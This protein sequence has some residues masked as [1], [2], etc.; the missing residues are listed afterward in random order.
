ME[1]NLIEAIK[2]NIS[3]NLATS[4]IPIMGVVIYG[5]W[6]RGMQTEH[7]DVDILVVSNAVNPHKHKRGKEIASLKDWLSTGLPLDVMLLTMDECISNF[8]NHNPLF[9]DIASEGIILIDSE[10]F[11]KNLIADTKNYIIQRGIIKLDD[12]WRFPSL[13]REPTYLSDVSNKD[14]AIAMITDGERDFRI[15]INIMEDGYFDKSVYHF[16][17]SVEKAVKAVLI[18]F[19]EF[20][21]SH[22]VGAVLI[23]K[24][25]EIELADNWEERLSYIAGISGEIEPEVTWSR[26]PGIEAGS[27]WLPYEEYKKEDAVGL[28]E[29]S[30]KVVMI[31]KDFI[32]WWFK[33]EEDRMSSKEIKD[34]E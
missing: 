12:G 27:L 28:K 17:Q 15:G 18:C 21:K 22:F 34:D 33:L 11:L 7:S 10:D 16:Q 9:L 2:K 29:K 24:L 5:S 14:F 20:K 1:K 13:Y 8:M 25:K 26:Y 4:P 32:K 23:E 30:E 19:G 6:A 3:N 31:T